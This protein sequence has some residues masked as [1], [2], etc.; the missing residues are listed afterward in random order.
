MY[1]NNIQQQQHSA[2]NLRKRNILSF[3]ELNRRN[4]RLIVCRVSNSRQS[5]QLLQPIAA[6]CCET[7]RATGCINDCIVYLAEVYIKNGDPLSHG[8][9]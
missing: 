9:V 7:V 5:S 2:Q 8:H 6:T 3:T 4:T 1:K